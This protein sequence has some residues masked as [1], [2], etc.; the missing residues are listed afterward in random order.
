[1]P[2]PPPRRSPGRVERLLSVEAADGLSLSGFVV[3]P[4]AGAR[5][6]VAWM[7]GFGVRSDQPQCV[8]LGRELADRGVAFVAG[9]LRGHDGAATG[10]RRRAD[11]SYALVRTG[12]W[13]E[14]FEESSWDVGAWLARAAALDAGQVVLAGHSFGAL[15]AVFHVS[16]RAPAI[17]G[18]A[19]A[20][21][22]FGLRHLD[23]E[24][25]GRA[26]ALA[27]AGRGEELL[28]EGSW[29]RGY[30]TRTVSAQTYASWWRV[31]PGFFEGPRT[32]FAD[33]R[34]PLLITY[35][36]AGDAGGQPEIDLLAGLATS[37]PRIDTRLLDGVTH[38]YAGG[39]AALALALVD[40]IDGAVLAPRKETGD[41]G[42]KT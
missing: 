39:E 9:D 20:S 8:T 1:M 16:E 23:P 18:L 7:H 40:W 24:I 25:A 12:S 22:S 26:Q 13:W 38:G 41:A 35:G 15:R 3:L 10:A 31:A 21:T 32:R 36:T 34:C 4:E 37:A 5:A 29:P 28:P 17:A 42:R 6:C 33:I 30:G 27:E 11:G 19:L 14:V 2:L